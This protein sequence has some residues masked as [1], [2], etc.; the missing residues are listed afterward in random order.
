MISEDDQRTGAKAFFPGRCGLVFLRAVTIVA[1]MST[2]SSSSSALDTVSPASAQARTWA[3]AWAAGMDFQHS[4]RVGGHQPGDHRAR[5][6]W[7]EQLRRR[8]STISARQ[9]PPTARWVMIFPGSW[10]AR[11]T[12]Y[13]KNAI[14]RLRSRPIAR[15]VCVS[16][17]PPGCDTSL[18]PSAD[19]MI[20]GLRAVRR[21]C[22]VPVELDPRQVLFPQLAGTLF[23]G[24]SWRK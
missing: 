23:L 14:G 18:V 8:C 11:S 22:K 5:A 9:S 10:T 15:N 4:G 1:S 3:A 6:R 17:I 24:S 20:F 12:R 13:R 21:I 7:P 19:T 16:G 2:V